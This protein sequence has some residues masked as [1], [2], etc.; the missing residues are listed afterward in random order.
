MLKHDSYCS[1][2]LCTTNSASAISSSMQ[3]PEVDTGR[4]PAHMNC[5]KAN[6]D[7]R[8]LMFAAID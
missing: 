4:I 8:G 1:N 2:K 5:P 3:Q 6:Y 7:T